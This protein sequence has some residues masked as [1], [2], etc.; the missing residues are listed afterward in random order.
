MEFIVVI[1]LFSANSVK[2]AHLRYTEVKKSVLVNNNLIYD[3][4]NYCH[5][6]TGMNISLKHGQ[7]FDEH[8]SYGYC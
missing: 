4:G 6:N 2:K 1:S 7:L 5:L 3:P 8:L